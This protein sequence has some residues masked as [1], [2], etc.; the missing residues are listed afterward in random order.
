MFCLVTGYFSSN[1]IAYEEAHRH[2][3]MV[4]NRLEREEFLQVRTWIYM[5]V[6]GQC[7]STLFNR[8]LHMVTPRQ[9]I[10]AEAN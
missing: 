9:W 2:A 1:K 6:G 4:K 3:I 5:C 7:F 8:R 10:L